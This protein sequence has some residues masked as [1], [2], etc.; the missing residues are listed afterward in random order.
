MT[1]YLLSVG[2]AAAKVAKQLPM[3]GSGEPVYFWAEN[4][5]VH[6]E[7]GRQHLPPEQRYGTMPWKEAAKRR[8]ALRDIVPESEKDGGS[9]WRYE[10]RRMQKFLCDMTLVIEEARAQGCPFAEDAGKEASRRR[11]KS[12]IVPSIVDL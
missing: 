2:R 8:Y 4:G 9:N 6:W 5:L 10:R 11:P 1:Q 12:I 7:D 3:F